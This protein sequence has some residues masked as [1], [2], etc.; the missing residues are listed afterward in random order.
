MKQARKKTQLEP[1]KMHRMRPQ[2]L[3]RQTVPFL[4]P[5]STN[6]KET[7][8]GAT[9]GPIFGT[10]RRSQKC[11]FFSIAALLSTVAVKYLPLRQPKNQIHLLRR[12]C[13]PTGEAP[14]C[15]A[16]NDERKWCQKEDRSTR[17]RF[18]S[19]H[20]APGATQKK[21]CCEIVSAILK[22]PCSRENPLSPLLRGL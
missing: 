14:Y 21:Q 11:F 18:D 16:K 6:Y 3:D 15:E 9:C 7:K 1:I 10:A 20:S 17:A 12:I 8:E 2:K 22:N 13:L 19:K 4:G 5:S